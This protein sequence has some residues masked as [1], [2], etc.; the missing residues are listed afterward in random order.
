MYYYTNGEWKKL[1]LERSYEPKAS[2]EVL[3]FDLI[4]N[5]LISEGRNA[6]LII[7]DDFSGYLII[8][9]L[10]SIESQK[11]EDALYNVFSTIGFP[12]IA[13][14]DC[15]RRIVN[16][17]N[18]LQGKIPFILSTSSPYFHNQNG[19]VEQGVKMFKDMARKLIFDPDKGL[20][21]SDWFKLL[22]IIAKTV[23]NLPL[24]N[25]K[26]TREEIF[27]KSSS[28]NIFSMIGAEKIFEYVKNN[29]QLIDKY[30]KIIKE[31]INNLDTD[32]SGNIGYY[33][34]KSPNIR[35]NEYSPTA[36]SEPSETSEL[37]SSKD[38]ENP[39][40]DITENLISDSTSL[41]E[42][43]KPNLAELKTKVQK[44]IAIVYEHL[45]FKNVVHE[46]TRSNFCK[47]ITVSIPAYITSDITFKP[48][49]E[50]VK[51]NYYDNGMI[52]T[53]PTNHKVL[54]LLND[55][56]TVRKSFQI[57][58]TYSYTKLKLGT[59]EYTFPLLNG[60]VGETIECEE[61]EN[62]IRP[63][64]ENA[65][66]KQMKYKKNMDLKVRQGLLRK[67]SAGILP[68]GNPWPKLDTLF[69][70]FNEQ[71]WHKQELIIDQ[72]SLTNEMHNLENNFIKIQAWEL[73]HFKIKYPHIT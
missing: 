37:E 55:C 30:E 44:S 67:L 13:R 2:R 46:T 12:K 57:K 25:S 5:L 14:S 42:D 4:P 41:D 17:L 34:S 54:E 16:A 24:T 6:I 68:T 28:N 70:M 26:V 66:L 23:N 19:K 43:E 69:P 3:S 38:N 47:S 11:S 56:P 15:D 61:L 58:K 20:N 18:N 40:P 8:V 59:R 7:I 27:F 62:W 33:T 21:K 36:H 65:N 31:N 22:P 60:N 35:R 45:H 51:L 29:D 32:D 72:E 49:L 39:E 48:V 50:L 52:P 73:G 71:H 1:I 9:G 63:D 64:I 53:H 10:K